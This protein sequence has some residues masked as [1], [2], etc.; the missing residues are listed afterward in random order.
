MTRP[1]VIGLTG[2][3]GMG[4]STTARMFADEG[5]PVWDADAAV[6]R[7]YA[8][9]GAAVDQIGALHPAAVRDGAVDRAALKS[10]IADDPAALQRIETVVHPLVAR[11]RAAFLADSRADIVLLDIPLLFETGAD[12]HVDAIVV[13]TAPAQVQRTRVLDRGTMTAAQFETILAKQTPDAEKRA[14]ADYIVETLTLEAARAAV[15]SCLR[16][17]RGR[18]DARNRAGH[19][20]D[21]V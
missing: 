17:I 9:G 6:H 1:F 13:V 20:N 14:R 2:S 8:A 10:W 5:I 12:K 11:D 18:L 3:I 19:G 4:K 16:D 21:G 15:Q 7:L